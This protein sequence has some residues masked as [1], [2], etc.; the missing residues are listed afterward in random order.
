M[1]TVLTD[2]CP[3]NTDWLILIA[4]HCVVLVDHQVGY[5]N[6]LYWSTTILYGNMDYFP[7]HR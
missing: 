3:R 2:N 5:G 1:M 7:D 6:T 4:P